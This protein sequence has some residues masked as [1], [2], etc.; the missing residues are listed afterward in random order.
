MKQYLT[1][2]LFFANLASPQSKSAVPL[3]AEPSHHQVLKNLFLSVFDVQAP[4]KASTLLHLHS[5]DYIYVTLGDA[6]I[7]NAPKGQ[8]PVSVHLND[9]D[10]KFAKGGLVHT[11]TN[12]GNHTFRNITIEFLSPSSHVHPCTASCSIP[13]T[14][15]LPDKSGCPKVEQLISA[16]QWVVTSITL[17]PAAHYR[18]H[19]HLAN[20]L[21]VPVTELDLKEQRQS[22]AETELRRAM[23]EISWN[24]PMVH[25]LTNAG[26]KP[27]KFIVLEL[28]G[29]PA[30]V[31]SENPADEK[32]HK[33]EPPHH[34]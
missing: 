1:V 4:P 34:H 18:Q 10:V 9:G 8:K 12:T 29:R 3:T 20:F 27:A 21:V 2:V 32:E 25:T 31:G 6:E 30:G 22:G 26:S 14:C 5:H 19:T 13:A 11:V 24:N 17:P 7:L 28:R 33:N 15:E 23:G 16:D